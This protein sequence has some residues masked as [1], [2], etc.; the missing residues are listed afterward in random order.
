MHGLNYLT[1]LLAS[2]SILLAD[3]RLPEL[4]RKQIGVT[5]EYDSS[6]VS[7]KYP[8]G[9]VPMDR[10][11][12]TDVVIRAMRLL[13]FDLQKEV[14]E[15]MKQ[16]FSA[17]PSKKNWG[18]KKPDKNI[19][20]RRVPNLRTFFTRKGWQVPITDNAADYLPGDI[21]TCTLGGKLPHI[22]IV[23]DRQSEDGT[24]LIIHNIGDGTQEEDLLFAFPINGHFRPQLKSN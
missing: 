19:D 13:N 4:A 9:D 23:S 18:L 2:C 6:Y 3:E 5:I 22:M 21:V 20:H 1:L 10:G 8:G 24:P 14:H 12:C 11:V 7:L 15:D 16:N 17:Y